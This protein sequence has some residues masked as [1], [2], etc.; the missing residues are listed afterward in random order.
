[1]PYNPNTDNPAQIAPGDEVGGVPI[2]MP[3]VG[4]AKHDHVGVSTLNQEFAVGA[5]SGRF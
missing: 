1:M 4:A 5:Q 3:Y 2:D